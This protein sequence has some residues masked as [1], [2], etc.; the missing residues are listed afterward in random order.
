MLKISF[1]LFL[2]VLFSSY[3][4]NAQV[5]SPYQVGTWSGFRTCAI[6]Y[7]FDDGCA[8]QF[9]KAIPLFD[10]VGYK[11]TLFTVTD[12][13]PNWTSLQNA[14]AKGH[15]VAS[16]TVTHPNLSTLTVDKQ[17]TEL[18]TSTSLI[19]SKVVSQKCLTMATPYCAKGNDALASQYYIA[20]RGCQGFIEPKTP[21]SFMN[22]SSVICGNLGSVFKVKD[23]KS[24]ADQAATSKGWLVYLIHGIDNDGGY[25]PLA[26]DTLNLSLKYLKENDGKFWVNTFGNVARYIKERNCV[27][28]I[29]TLATETDISLALT[30]TLHNNEWY[31]YPLTIRRSLP[32]A[33]TSALVTQNGKL[34]NTSLVEV[35]S[36][37]YLQFDAV[38]DGGSIVISKAASTGLFE[39]KGS[40]E[41]TKFKVWTDRKTIFFTV[42]S[43]C[44]PNPTLSLFSSNGILVDSFNKCQIEG[45]TGKVS[46]RKLPKSGV[47]VVR[48]NDKRSSWSGQI[49]LP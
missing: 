35:N 7:T 14:A 36:V 46:L 43:A 10:E 8:N 5:V 18:E 4:V 9:T 49:I 15:E 47:F 42:P 34:V 28:V 37:K 30:D 27:S 29:E 24:K 1:F 26:S 44:L 2:A 11:L 48:L 13:S 45:E 22:V 40:S 39:L 16:H 19:N 31:N 32:S 33:W 25:S 21:G 12:W 38:P 20:V 23:F 17:K 6:S 3:T 41:Q